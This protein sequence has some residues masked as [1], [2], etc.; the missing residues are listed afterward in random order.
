MATPPDT[1]AF[2]DAR[3]IE[4]SQS[5]PETVGLIRQQLENGFGWLRFEPK[6][7]QD[8]RAHNNEAGLVNRIAL[9]AIALTVLLV[10]L[11]LA[12]IHISIRVS[13]PGSCTKVW[14]R[15]RGQT[16]CTEELD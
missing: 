11:P 7:E 10:I 6:L 2:E 12:F 1:N 3:K 14:C 8:F 16:L 9:L 13:E 5:A 4:M 15:G